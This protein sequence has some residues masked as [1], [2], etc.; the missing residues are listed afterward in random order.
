MPNFCFDVEE[1]LPDGLIIGRN[2]YADIP[3]GTVFT[4]LRKSKLVGDLPNFETVDLG[5]FARVSLQLLEVQWYRRS[6]DTIPRGHTAGLRV[7]GDGM[8]LLAKAL[9]E[10]G[11]RETV[12]LQCSF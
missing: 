6:I 12:M 8:P 4:A 9:V 5:E 11:E 3:L 1:I 10:R 2:G 7:S